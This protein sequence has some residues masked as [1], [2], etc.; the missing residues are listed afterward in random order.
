MSD[1][2]LIDVMTD[3]LAEIHAMRT[4][5]EKRFEGMDKRFENMD[6]RLENLEK[7]QV[8]TNQLLSENTRAI[9][10]IAHEIRVVPQ[11]EQRIGKLEV[12]VFGSPSPSLVQESK[13]KYEKKKLES[14]EKQ[15]VK[16]NQLLSENTRAILKIAEEIRAI[17][18]HERKGK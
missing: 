11:H 16:T 7:S 10:K 6:K 1:K 5:F 8:K 15:Q 3:V 4:G 18:Q 13:G 17:P 12:E 9:L 14:L 2:K